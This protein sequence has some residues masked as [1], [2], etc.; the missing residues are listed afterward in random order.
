MWMFVVGSWVGAIGVGAIV[1]IAG[2][3]LLTA[4]KRVDGRSSPR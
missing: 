2:F 4:G 1:G 3:S